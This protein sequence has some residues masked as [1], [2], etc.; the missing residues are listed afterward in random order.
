MPLKANIFFSLLDSITMGFQ[1]LSLGHNSVSFYQ[2]C[3][4]LVAPCT[5]IIQRLAYG[6]KLPSVPV[7][8]SLLILL[9]GIAIATITDIS[10]NPLGTFFG[11][12][13]TCLVCLVAIYTNTMQKTHEISS[14][15]M[16]LNVAPMEGAMLLVIGPIWDYWI[17]NKTAYTD[18]EWN[19]GAAYAV[20]GTCA[21]AVS[22]NAATFFLLG[23]TSPVSYQVIGHLKTVLVL[24]GGFLL[25]D[26]D[27][28][29]T[30]IGGVVFAF[31]G[32]LLYAWLKDREMRRA[33]MSA[34]GGGV[35]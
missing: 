7:M 23:K 22:V 3:K 29:Y 11:L 1:N 35:K 26:T 20:A 27:A 10:L 34:Q 21:L 15:Q 18:F 25:F 32:C 19:I 12:S 31:V 30:T 2:M 28:N 14:F 17:H 6:E 13:S 24:G 5:V 8:F 33:M 16:L 4:L 9:F